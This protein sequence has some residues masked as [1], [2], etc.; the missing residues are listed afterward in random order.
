MGEVALAGEVKDWLT[1][2]DI[3]AFVD[4]RQ[5]WQALESLKVAIH[6]PLKGYSF[7]MLEP[8]TTSSL[9][10]VPILPRGE[11]FIARIG[12]YARKEQHPTGADWQYYWERWQVFRTD[13][14]VSILQK[15]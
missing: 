9:L 7:Y 4:P 13:S 14:A 6:H 1:I 15:P 2:G 10:T 5:H 3:G 8:G 12:I 11:A